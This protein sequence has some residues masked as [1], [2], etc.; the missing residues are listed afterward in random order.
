[1]LVSSPASSDSSSFASVLTFLPS[2]PGLSRSNGLPGALECVWNNL[3]ERFLGADGLLL[4]LLLSLLLDFLLDLFL[5]FLLDVLVKR[6]QAM[7]LATQSK[8]L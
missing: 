6:W 1:M 8:A 3:N 7:L 5:Y 2:C 4:H